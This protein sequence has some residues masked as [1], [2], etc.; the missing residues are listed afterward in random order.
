MISSTCWMKRTARH[1]RD[2]TDLVMNHTSDQHPWFQAA[3]AAAIRPTAIITSGAIQMI[4]STGM[5][6]SSSWIPKNPTG[7]GMSRP[8]S[9][10]WHRFYSS[11]PDLNYDNPAVQQ[12]M[13]NVMSFWLDLG[14]DG[15]RADAVP[16]LFEREGTNCENL[17]ETHAYL[18]RSAPLHGRELSRAHPAVR[19]QPVAGG[20]APVFWRWAMSST[21]AFTSRSCRASTWR[22]AGTS[23]DAAGL[24]SGAHP[25]HPG[26]LPVV[27]LPAQPRRADPGDGH[28][29]RAPVDV[30][31][32]CP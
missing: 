7:P 1:A 20:C 16:Y 9:I 19:S 21:W 18:K 27:H 28:R 4:R 8:G 5:R 11:Q 17:P 14:I 23:T 29:G 24:D 15:F 31:G 2:L 32:I 3:R 26:K 13:L 12:E 6:A 22:C 10:F 30:A 25:A